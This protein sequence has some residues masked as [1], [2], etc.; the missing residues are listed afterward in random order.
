MVPA[1]VTPAR[2]LARLMVAA[3]LAILLT[4]L[5]TVGAVGVAGPGDT[6]GA[7]ADATATATP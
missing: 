6:R 3:F 4:L 2:A 5:L 7:A 1:T